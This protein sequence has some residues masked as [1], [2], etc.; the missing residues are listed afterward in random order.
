[1]FRE[2]EER[3]RQ[4]A[5][6]IWVA[7]GRPDGRHEEHWQMARELIAQQDNQRQTLRPNPAQ[8]GEPV[9]EQPVEPVLAAES[10]GDLPDL[11]DQAEGARPYPS[12]ER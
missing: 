2:D 5:H 6:E 9:R 4:K 12:R 1:M 7:E 11:D 3:I 8:D 10:L